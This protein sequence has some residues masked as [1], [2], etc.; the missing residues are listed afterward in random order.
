[1]VVSPVVFFDGSLWFQGIVPEE[2]AITDDGMLKAVSASRSIEGF[3][4]SL[5]DSGVLNLAR[6]YSTGEVGINLNKYFEQQYKAGMLSGAD[7]GSHPLIAGFPEEVLGMSEAKYRFIQIL[8][9]CSTYGLKEAGYQGVPQGWFPQTGEEGDY[10][11]QQKKYYDRMTVIDL[12]TDKQAYDKVV[13]LMSSARRLNSSEIESVVEVLRYCDKTHAGYYR[14]EDFKPSFK[15]DGAVIIKMAMEKHL[16]S[17]ELEGFLWTFT[18]NPTDV[19]KVLDLRRSVYRDKGTNDLFALQSRY[20]ADNTQIAKMPTRYKRAFVRV[21]DYYGEEPLMTALADASKELRYSIR[22]ISYKRFTVYPERIQKIESIMHREVRGFNSQLQGVF[23]GLKDGTVTMEEAKRVFSLRPGVV[24][25]ELRHIIRVTGVVSLVNKGDDTTV[26]YNDAKFKELEKLV[27]DL[28][29]GMSLS[30]L[31]R[32]CTKFSMRGDVNVTSAMTGEN[33][34]YA[35]VSPLQLQ[36][37]NKVVSHLLRVALRVNLAANKDERIAGKK[38][39]LDKNG[40]S[41]ESSLVLTNDIG[42]NAGSVY[43]AGIALEMP[44]NINLLRFFLFWQDTEKQVDLDL[45]A[46]LLK[47]GGA[48]EHIGW[49]SRYHKGSAVY[50]SGDVTTS[51]NPAEEYIDVNFHEARKQ[52]IK[53]INIALQDYTH[54]KDGFAGV[55]KALFGVEALEE[56]TRAEKLYAPKNV[57]FQEDL[58]SKGTDLQYAYVD[59]DN[60]ALRFMRGVSCAG[61]YSYTLKNYLDDITEAWGIDLVDSSEQA[62]VVVSLGKVKGSEA[63]DMLEENFFLGK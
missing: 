26:V 57:V 46:Y 61:E 24:M 38:V 5:S 47:E 37:E 7:F 3:G 27:E 6:C 18:T 20:R 2:G 1:M 31:V 42:E 41:L 23:K 14:K 50:T 16:S 59:I 29:V 43:P 55:Q 30:N 35:K 56:G 32:A 34:S 58:N 63:I 49:N 52:G 44:D 15:E 17:L 39:Y 8:H 13:K 33:V 25:R 51:F 48:K 4:Y 36:E 21:L 53:G 28:S 45:H 11:Q 40:V 9:Y 60:K 19:L 22:R 10:S 12:L 62:D 54:E